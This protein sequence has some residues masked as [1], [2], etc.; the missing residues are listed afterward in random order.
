MYCEVVPSC[1]GEVHKQEVAE[2]YC[3]GLLP[4]DQSSRWSFSLGIY[5]AAGLLPRL[6]SAAG[7][8]PCVGIV[9][10]YLTGKYCVERFFPG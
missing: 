6:D 3:A 1:V 7:L 10:G 8:F 4:R 2:D 9:R 5:R